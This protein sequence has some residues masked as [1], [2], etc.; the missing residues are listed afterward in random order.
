MEAV[1]T[2]GGDAVLY[3]YG[4]VPAGT[5]VSTVAAS[6]VDLF[7]VELG[8]VACAAGVV[9]AMDYHLPAGATGAEQLEWIAP[10]VWRHHE[11]LTRL[12]A[13]AAVVPLK[14]G[15]LCPAAAEAHGMLGR[16]GP[17]I[18]ALLARFHGKDE[19]TLTMSADGSDLSAALQATRPELVALGEE[20]RTLPEGRAYFARKKLQ[21]A[22]TEA[23]DAVLA[24]IEQRV[25]E[26]VASAGV[27]RAIEA[28]TP[29]N[30]AA[31]DRFA[32]MAV[33]VE[34]SRFAELE[35]VLRELEAEYTTPPV[36]FE[37]VGPWPPYS[38]VTGLDLTA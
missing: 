3:L 33:L 24:H 12:Q 38:F 37:L 9:K 20:A 31:R 17:S 30:A 26:R 23:A 27:E 2:A 6:G 35:T 25:A 11:V 18:A 5:D 13:S 19:W 1:T 7:L 36:T 28:R 14:F 21:Q 22:T 15:T 32:S 10:R 4:F 8:D 16:L 34:R 29:G